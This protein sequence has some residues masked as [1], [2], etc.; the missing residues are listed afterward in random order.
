MKLSAMIFLMKY[1]SLINMKGSVNINCLKYKEYRSSMTCALLILP[2][3]YQ[4]RISNSHKTKRKKG[5]I[6]LNVARELQS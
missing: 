6:D 2:H 1:A 4:E 3:T 5:D